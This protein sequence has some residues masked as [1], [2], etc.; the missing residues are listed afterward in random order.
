[1]DPNGYKYLIPMSDYLYFYF[2]ASDF[3]DFF[4]FLIILF[5]QKLYNYYY[6]YYTI[7][8]LCFTN[9]GTKL[10]AFIM[11]RQQIVVHISQSMA[12]VVRN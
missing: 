7:L 5:I 3:K 11:Y 1:M 9:S 12:G 6:F 10:Y 4:F 8:Y 2:L